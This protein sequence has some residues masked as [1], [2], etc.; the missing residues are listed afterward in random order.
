MDER[1][2][3][4]QK[5]TTATPGKKKPFRFALIA[6]VVIVAVAAAI[7]LT[8]RGGERGDVRAENGVVTLPLQAVAD[9]AAHYYT[10][11]TAD[12]SAVRFFVLK[13]HDGVVRAAFDACDECY[14]SGKG[15]RHE[16]DNM[17][18]NNCGQ[19]FASD[20]INEVKGGCNPAPLTRT[21][22]DNRV[23]IN[24]QDLIAGQGYFPKL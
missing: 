18:C 2:E 6:L 3:K 13:S 4:Q 19:K 22:A 20:R 21:V 9:G 16:G 11:R 5:F 12:G 17:V 8:G 15:Y 1:Q 24:E 14:R 23:L 10:Y 7:V